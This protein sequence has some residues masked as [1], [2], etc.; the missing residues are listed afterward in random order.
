MPYDSAEAL[1]WH[2]C[3]VVVLENADVCREQHHRRCTCTKHL[4]R[5]FVNS[6]LWVQEGLVLVTTNAPVSHKAAA[7]MASMILCQQA[8]SPIPCALAAHAQ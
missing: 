2:W 6:V 7:A 3:P 8:Q 4:R 5:C 1:A